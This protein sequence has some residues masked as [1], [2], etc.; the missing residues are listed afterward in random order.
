MTQVFNSAGNVQGVTVLEAGPCAVTQV[1]FV[2]ND[3]YNAIQLSFGKKK[4]EIRVDNPEGYKVGQEI[5][6]DIFKVGDKVKVSGHTIG[7][8][9]AG[10]VKRFHMH[11]GPMAHGS[12]SH[13]IPGSIGSGTT[14]GRVWPGKKMPGRLGGGMATVKS[15]RVAQV[16]PERNLILVQG[17]V[18]GKRGNLVLVR[19]A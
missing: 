5:K 6:V 12:K 11:R 18:P 7:K 8:G 17:S 9:F 2:K 19:K 4:R 3:G 16:I 13:R 14:P 10:T 15:L 1:K